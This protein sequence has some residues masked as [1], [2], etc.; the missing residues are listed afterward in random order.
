VNKERT[1]LTI[2]PIC[3]ESK[4]DTVEYDVEGKPSP[5]QKFPAEPAGKHEE[6]KE[7]R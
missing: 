7:R 2:P 5:N 3:K 6:T 1:H 4:M